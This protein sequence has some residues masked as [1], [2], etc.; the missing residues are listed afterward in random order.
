D[1]DPRGV[2]VVGDKLVI[3]DWRSYEVRVYRRHNGTLLSSSDKLESGPWG[4]CRVSDREFCVVMGDAGIAIMAV[5]ISGQI[6]RVKTFRLRPTFDYCTGVALWNNTIVVSGVKDNTIYWC[7]VSSQDGR[8]EEL[9]KVCGGDFSSLTVKHD[10]LYV[11]CCADSPDDRGVYGLNLLSPRQPPYTYKPEGLTS[12]IT[13]D[14]V[15]HLF[16][17]YGSSS[18][19]HLTATCQLVAIYEDDVPRDHLAIFWDSGVLYLTSYRSHVITMYKTTQQGKL[20]VLFLLHRHQQHIYYNF[21]I[22]TNILKY[23]K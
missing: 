22:K 14:D 4:V 20:P 16:V 2:V 3:T 17:C 1:L 10:M 7:V 18:I 19:H 8:P 21:I 6:S 9:H 5:K 11:S 13:V 12:G 23:L 15:G